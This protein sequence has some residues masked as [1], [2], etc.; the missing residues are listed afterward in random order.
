MPTDSPA[1]D[2]APRRGAGLA[3]AVIALAAAGVVV[4]GLAARS[5]D[6]ARLRERAQAQS[7]PVV[8]V[9]APGRAP[10]A[11]ALELPG[12][13]EANARAVVSARV[14]GYLKAWHADIGA[15]VKAGQLLAEIETPDL[16]QQLLQ[17][18]AE[19]ANA[20]ANAALSETTAKR[21]RSLL[22]T[23]AV[24]RQGVDEREA[25]LAAKLSL[26]RALEANVDRYRA[27]KQFSRIVSPFDGVVTA[28]STD[29]G[30]LVNAGGSAG[31]ELFVVSDT[32]RL[33]V[34]ASVPQGYAASIQPGAKAQVTV[35][36][37]PGRAYAATVQ[38][39][40]GAINAT[41]GT[42]LVQLAAENAEGELL[43]GAFAMVRLPLPATP[44]AI[45]LPPSALLYGK[46]GPRVALVDGAG[47]VSLAPVTVARDLGR[48]VE[49]AT[50][51]AEGDRVI[52][53]PPDGIASGDTV[54]PAAAVAPAG[55][56][57]R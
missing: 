20:R 46:A 41:T 29:V 11:A 47:K 57:K 2:R 5:S 27:L 35:P 28:R 56:P 21:W 25:D 42:M 33:R 17:A 16:D 19:L 53:N 37:R 1:P 40:A 8:S 39:L 12:R 7:V 13:I 34:Y 3:L 30:A 43:P 14:S 54:R 24:S 51:L 55:A 15:R 10:A 50:G 9:I 31:S 36:E 18:E 4:A 22:A 52:D 23:N 45:T 26:V 6:A 44:G 32:R 49:I 38:S 48:I